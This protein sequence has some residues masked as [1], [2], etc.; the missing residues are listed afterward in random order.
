MHP[1]FA[2][3]FQYVE[4]NYRLISVSRNGAR[5]ILSQHNSFLSA[6]Q[7]LKQIS[8]AEGVVIRIEAGS[9]PLPFREQPAPVGRL[10]QDSH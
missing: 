1:A 7:A 6:E 5:T 9:R 8:A 10:R 3:K 4:R 2:N